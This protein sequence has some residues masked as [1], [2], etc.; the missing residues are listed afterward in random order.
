MSTTEYSLKKFPCTKKTSFGSDILQ[1]GY[2]FIQRY[3][4]LV[5]LNYFAADTFYDI[6]HA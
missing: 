2:F 5:Q 4:P 6:N 1:A 3:S